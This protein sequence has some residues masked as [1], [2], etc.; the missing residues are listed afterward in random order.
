MSGRVTVW[1]AYEEAGCVAAPVRASLAH[2][3]LA[4]GAHMPRSVL[5]HVV[6][7]AGIAMRRPNDGPA[8]TLAALGPSDSS[9]PGTPEASRTRAGG[10]CRTTV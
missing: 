7:C 3:T 6:V 9:P 8:P 4:A 5:I 1:F 10:S 2:A